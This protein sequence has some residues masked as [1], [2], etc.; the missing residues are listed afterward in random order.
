MN[1]PNEWTKFFHEN[2]GRYRYKHK[3]SGLIRDTLMAIGKTFKGTAKNVVKTA[4]DKAA[5]TVAEKAGQKVGEIAVEKGSKQ[6]QQILRKRKPKPQKVSQDAKKK[7]ENILQNQVPKKTCSIC[8]LEIKSNFGKRNL[9]VKFF[10][11]C[12]TVCVEMFSSQPYLEKTAYVQVNLDTPLTYPGNN[13]TQ[14]KSG[15]KF[16]VRDRDIFL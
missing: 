11:L 10:S 4:A 9:I 5:K 15:H 3:G 1:H 8:R 2:A 12:I 16:T 14:N 7:L 6:I 13:Q